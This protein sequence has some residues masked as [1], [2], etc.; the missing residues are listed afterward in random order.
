VTSTNKTD[1]HDITEVALNII[2]LTQI[3]FALSSLKNICGN[4]Y[5]TGPF[6]V[7]VVCTDMFIIGV[8]II[9]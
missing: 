1:L 9:V 7:V 3:N 8:I 5:H 6:D 2:T 4:A